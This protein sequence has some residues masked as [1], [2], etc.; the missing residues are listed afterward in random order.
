[1]ISNPHN[2]HSQG[3]LNINKKFYETKREVRT[4]VTQLLKNVNLPSSEEI[5]NKIETFNKKLLMSIEFNLLK[6]EG[7]RH[8]NFHFEKKNR[9]DEMREIYKD[10][11]NIVKN[12]VRPAQLLKS[13]LTVEEMEMLRNDVNYFIKDPKI[14]S[15]LSF[16]KSKNLVDILNEEELKKLYTINKRR[17]NLKDGVNSNK[18]FIDLKQIQDAILNDKL[19]TNRNDVGEYTNRKLNLQVTKFDAKL[20]Q[21][22][23]N[24]QPMLKAKQEKIQ[25]KKEK[26]EESRKIPEKI[27]IEMAKSLYGNIPSSRAPNITLFKNDHEK[28]YY[29][30]NEFENI[31]SQN[32]STTL[33]KSLE[34]AGLTL[35]K[36]IN[37]ENPNENNLSPIKMTD[38]KNYTTSAN[39]VENG[40]N[41][42]NKKSLLFK[43][44]KF[45]GIDGNTYNG[46]YYKQTEISQIYNNQQGTS[47]NSVIF[48]DTKSRQ[49]LQIKERNKKIEKKIFEYREKNK[50]SLI[51]EMV[52]KNRVNNI[53]ENFL[54]TN[55]KSMN[56]VKIS[57]KHLLTSRDNSKILNVN[58]LNKGSSSKIKNINGYFHGRRVIKLPT[59]FI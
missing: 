39:Y 27:F 45:S 34:S 23:K 28:N 13:N 12:Q 43:E 54:I 47:S 17:Q 33:G 41:T 16:L 48:T 7:E 52:L 10:T 49:I 6:E 55:L 5:V 25:E 18:L 37:K 38:F 4:K 32:N 44:N 26:Q 8:Q 11:E 29:S 36:Q 56:G 21:A 22:K 30:T 31:N 1:M 2:S 40:R 19:G 51:D 59:L 57:D 20:D 50:S 46:T 3:K 14:K 42:S 9:L 53:R 35:H 15:K 58:I 24:L